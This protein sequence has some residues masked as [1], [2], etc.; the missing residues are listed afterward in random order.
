MIVGA[1]ALVSIAAPFGSGELDVVA[2]FLYWLGMISIGWLQWSLIIWTLHRVTSAAPLPPGV[3]GTVAAFIFSALMALEINLVHGWLPGA[4]GHKGVVPFF[5]LLGVTLAFCWFGQLLVRFA[6]TGL[7]AGAT[8]P[9]GGGEVRFLRRIPSRIAGDLLCLRTEDHYLR[10]HTT[11]GSDL[12]LFRLKDALDELKGLDGM[13]VHRSYWVARDA[14][15]TVK[16]KGRKTA[17]ILTSGMQIP[18]SERF[19]PALRGAGWLG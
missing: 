1:S 12:I 19:L 4:P 17:L 6:A 5:V 7:P 2:R 8:G 10:I 16:G 9:H 11:V 15:K 13:Q 3:C 14:I 18:V